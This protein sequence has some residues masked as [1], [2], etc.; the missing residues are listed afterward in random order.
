MEFDARAHVWF[1]I[2]DVSQRIIDIIWDRAFAMAYPSAVVS[3]DP[4]PQP[5]NLGLNDGEP[6]QKH[7][8]LPNFAILEGE[9]SL[10]RIQEK[11]PI[12]DTG[13]GNVWR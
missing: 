9:T 13:C 5:N 12:L 2:A 7:L 3:S 1:P 8:P 4:S 11:D 6:Q 10:V